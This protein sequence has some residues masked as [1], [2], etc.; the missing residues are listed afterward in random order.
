VTS[1]ASQPKPDFYTFIYGVNDKGL[2]LTTAELVA[3]GM[4][5]RVT[6]N[7]ARQGSPLIPH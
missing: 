4:L 2:V 7:A 5:A 1:A 3:S 6:G